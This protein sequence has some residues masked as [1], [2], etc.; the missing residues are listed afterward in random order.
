MAL[1]LCCDV[2]GEGP[3]QERVQKVRIALGA[4]GR[5]RENP[6]DLPSAP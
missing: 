5:A 2:L 4:P 6:N 1:C 3:A